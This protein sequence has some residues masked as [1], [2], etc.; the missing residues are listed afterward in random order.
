M[1]TEDR[2]LFLSKL[3]Y[4]D[5]IEGCTGEKDCYYQR[6]IVVATDSKGAKK[7]CYMYH[8]TNSNLPEHDESVKVPHGDWLKRN[9]KTGAA[10]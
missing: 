3:E 2:D 10:V 6:S 5:Q 9:N 7:V 1:S 8:A 4:F